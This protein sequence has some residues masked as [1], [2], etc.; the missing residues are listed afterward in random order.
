MWWSK[1]H[2][3]E[4]PGFLG[5]CLVKRSTD[6]VVMNIVILT[7][8]RHAL[9][10]R[11]HFLSLGS[12]G[13]DYVWR[14]LDS[15][16]F[17]GLIRLL[18]LLNQWYRWALAIGMKYCLIHLSSYD[19]ECILL[20]YMQHL[21]PHMT[22]YLGKTINWCGNSERNVKSLIIILSYLSI[23]SLSPPYILALTRLLWSSLTDNCNNIFGTSCSSV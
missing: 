1:L 4:V 23:A 21:Q 14:Y 18:V 9:A 15:L 22:L 3:G 17:P 16:S 2:I 20:S 19:D 11:G 8:P 13:N 12:W 5:P 10:C 6:R 7:R